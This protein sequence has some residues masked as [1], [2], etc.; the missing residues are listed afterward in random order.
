MKYHQKGLSLVEL[1]IA[2]TIG[3]ILLTGVV[4]VFLSSKTTYSNQQALSR[5]QE[6]GRLAIEFLSKDIRMA[7]YTGC[8]SRAGALPTNTLKTPTAFKF[9]FATAIVGYTSTTLPTAHGLS[10]APL[11]SPVTD[12][13]SVRGATGTGIE[14]NLAN[15]ATQVYIKLDAATTETIGCGSTDRVSGFC[16]NDIVMI[17]DC[18]KARVFQI[19]G[20]TTVA[21]IVLDHASSAT[22]APSGN[23]TTSWPTATADDIYQ[24]GA[25]VMM[26]FNTT[27]F[28]AAGTSGRPSLYQS[29]NGA[30]TASELLEGVDNISITYGVDAS[31]APPTT[32]DYIPESYETAATVTAANNWSKVRSVRIEV[33]VASIEDNVL[34]EKQTYTFNSTPTTATD[35]RL[36]QIFT[37]TIGIR[38]RLN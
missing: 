26:A 38:S 35:R 25:E 18:A 30:A 31:P 14:V 1:M 22:V 16:V 3:L 15:T 7:G 28:I 27:Y 21:P 23:A 12:V 33:L 10:P 37:T 20:M 36:R 11:T 5:V 8:A 29:T 2:M 24:P 13:I 32:P 6:T 4:K 19:T 17:A 9:D 34:A